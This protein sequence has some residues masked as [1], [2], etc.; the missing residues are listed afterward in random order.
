MKT[1]KLISMLILLAILSFACKKD[2][3]DKVND[4]N[5]N[6]SL[7]SDVKNYL[8][9]ENS[10]YLYKYSIIE[11]NIINSSNN[12]TLESF[13][14]ENINEEKG[15]TYNIYNVFT[16]HSL[17][18]HNS[19]NNRIFGDATIISSF[20]HANT[21]LELFNLSKNEWIA[22]DSISTVN[23]QRTYFYLKVERILPDEKI[24][25]K[26]SAITCIKF[27]YDYVY[28]FDSKTDTTEFEEVLME[29]KESVVWFAKNLGMIKEE[30]D[31]F[32]K[33]QGSIM[34]R[35]YKVELVDS[36]LK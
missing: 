35:E 6:D 15:I 25:Y 18:I 19:N 26:D 14:Y 17:S 16:N 20:Y 24:V 1:T 21:N 36:Y 8:F 2:D 29:E 22:I 10:K 11:D 23:N 12:I 7:T 3:N 9:K 31:Y 32:R 28:R 34:K 30:L 5:I 4:E 13:G 33:H 27:K